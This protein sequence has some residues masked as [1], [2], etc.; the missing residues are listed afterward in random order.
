MTPFENIGGSQ[1]RCLT[2]LT[3]S[4][5]KAFGKEWESDSRLSGLPTVRSVVIQ[6]VKTVYE[7]D[8]MELLKNKQDILRDGHW[9]HYRGREELVL[10][11]PFPA[12]ALISVEGVETAD[13]VTDYLNKIFAQNRGRYPKKN[14]WQAIAAHSRSPMPLD[15][16]HPFFRYKESRVLDARCCRFL[17]V[18]DMAV[19]GMNNKYLLV[20][21]AAELCSSIRK[22]VQRLGRPARSVAERRGMQFV[23]P[24]AS[25]DQVYVI[26]HEMFASLPDARGV[27]TSTAATIRDALSFIVDMRYATADIMTLEEY[28]EVEVSEQ[29]LRDDSRAAQLTRWTKCQILAQLG[30][31]LRQGR[32]PQVARIVRNFGGSSELRRHFIRAFAQSALDHHPVTVQQVRDGVVV[33]TEIDAIHDLKTRVLRIAPP[34][35]QDVLEAER[36]TQRTLDMAGAKA[37]LE[38]YSWTQDMLAL[39]AEP[40][41]EKWLATVAG[42][43]R[44]VDGPHD[45]TEFDLRQTPAARISAMANEIG[46]RLALSGESLER[47]EHLV[48]EGTLHYLPLDGATQADLEEGGRYCRPEITF[49]LRNEQFVAQMQAWACFMLL[50]EGRLDDLWAVLRFERFWDEGQVDR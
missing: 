21:G 17:V 35:R 3:V 38:Q 14:G 25:H 8:D 19:E 24:P 41:G 43:W 48:L 2:V 10:G 34:D 11:E 40:D 6:V 39:M 16:N 31:S 27:T 36:M 32:R 33:Q 22:A 9:Q 4:E 44:T 30:A 1:P 23:I 7:L 45:R 47:T 42:I 37:W 28:V 12:H 46:S 5:Q 29:E 49:A 20:W 15:R 13:E 50:S 26:T 18:S